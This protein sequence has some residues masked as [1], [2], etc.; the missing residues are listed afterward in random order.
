MC[1]SEYMYMFII[2]RQFAHILYGHKT[3]STLIIIVPCTLIFKKIF[4]K[5]KNPVMRGTVHKQ[6]ARHPLLNML[7]S[8]CPQKATHRR[9]PALLAPPPAIFHGSPGLAEEQDTSLCLASTAR[10][11]RGG[12][13][14]ALLW[15]SAAV[16]VSPQDWEH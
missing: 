2:H 6:N 7:F 13:V 12:A 10:V 11:S 9:A 16:A 1:I 4:F 8:Q 14:T 3:M 5:L 15:L